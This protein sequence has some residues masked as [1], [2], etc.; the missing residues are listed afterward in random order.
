MVLFP[1]WAGRNSSVGPEQRFWIFIQV[2]CCRDRARTL[3]CILRDQGA[4]V[5]FTAA[6]P[7]D[8]RRVTSVQDKLYT[9]VVFLARHRSLPGLEI[10]ATAVTVLMPAR[11]LVEPRGPRR[12]LLIRDS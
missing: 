9:R 2:V 12:W 7:A 5:G 11:Y 10:G 6:A 4:V 1:L 3:H 8:V